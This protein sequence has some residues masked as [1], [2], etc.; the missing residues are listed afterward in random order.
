[1]AAYDGIGGIS[2]V[3]SLS[4]YTGK[5]RHDI[6]PSEINANKFDS[7]H[8][9]GKQRGN[10][11]FRKECISR[12]SQE[13]RTSTSTSEILSLQKAVDEGTYVPDPMAIAGRMLLLYE[14]R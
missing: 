12:I 1:M 14:D 4:V 9:S 2:S 10:D 5:M 3:G 13:L 6:A 7:V 8:I 11:T